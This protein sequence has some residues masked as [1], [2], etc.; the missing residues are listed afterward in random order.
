LPCGRIGLISAVNPD[1]YPM[2]PFTRKP[3]PPPPADFIVGNHRATY[4][5]TLEEW[6]FEM[7]NIEFTLSGREID[8]QA[9]QWAQAALLDIKRLLPEIDREVLKVLEDGPCNAAAR[10]LLSVSLDDYASE[11]Q[12]DLAFVGD[13]SWGDFGVNVILADGKIVDAYGGD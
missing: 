4:S 10:E 9:F 8:P 6:E 3:V 12:I 1:P 5:P 11:G 7:E 13:D 2:W